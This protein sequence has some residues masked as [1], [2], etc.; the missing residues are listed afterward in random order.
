MVYA[1]GDEGSSAIGNT[2]GGRLGVRRREILGKEYK[3]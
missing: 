1:V 3:I 2:R